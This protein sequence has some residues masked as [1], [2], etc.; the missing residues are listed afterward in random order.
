MADDG[1]DSAEHFFFQEGWRIRLLRRVAGRMQQSHLRE[2]WGETTGMPRGNF[3]GGGLRSGA[4]KCILPHYYI[5]SFLNVTLCH[6]ALKH[7]IGG[8]FLDSRAST[9]PE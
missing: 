9:L 7:K 4:H 8:R 1:N 6:K 5:V 3:M 2:K